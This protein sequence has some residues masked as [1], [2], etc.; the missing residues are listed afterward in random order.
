MNNEEKIYNK[1]REA[2]HN[3]SETAFPGM[4]KVWNR[5][6]EKIDNAQTKKKSAFWKKLTIAASFLLFFMVGYQLFQNQEQLEKPLELNKPIE[7]KETNLEGSK[8]NET[9]MDD[10]KI[11]TNTNSPKKEITFPSTIT[12]VQDDVAVVYEKAAL[13][14]EIENETKQISATVELMSKSEA[15]ERGYMNT[16]STNTPDFLNNRK[17]YEA[18][19]VKSAFVPEEIDDKSEQKALQ[20]K[21]ADLLLIDDELSK[22]TVEDINLENYEIKLHLTN[23]L[24]IINGLEYSEESLFGENPTSPYAPLNKQKI[25]EIK[26]I[27]PNDAKSTYGDKGKN[28]VVIITI[29]K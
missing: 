20:Q 27:E 13:D 11:S 2:S 24:Y 5:V 9:P 1:I 15:I 8:I 28:G 19:V 21:P 16:A 26:I 7:T 14:D 18:K 6:E 4:E 3:D 25:K 22:K 12:L 17:I 23:P 29:K 10:L